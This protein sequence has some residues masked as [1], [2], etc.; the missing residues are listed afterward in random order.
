MSAAAAQGSVTQP[1]FDVL[2]VRL[3]PRRRREALDALREMLAG[4]GAHSLYFV[5]AATANLAAENPAY[6]ETLNRGHLVLN[7]G[8]GVKLAARLQGVVLEDNLVG[9][10]LIAQLLSEPFERPLRVYLLGGRPGVAERAAAHV[11]GLF[12]GVEVAAFADGYCSASEEA[13]VVERIGRLRPDLLLVAMGN[14]LQEQFID[15]HLARLGCRVAAGVGGLF[16]H[17]AG[18]LRRAP[19]WMRRLGL[20]WCQLL[21]QQPHKWRRYLP[22]NL[23]FLWRVWRPQLA[24]GARRAAV[25]ALSFAIALA[26]AEGVV[27]LIRPQILE[28]YPDGLYVPSASRQYKLRPHFRGVFRYPEF[29]TEVRISGQGLREDREYSPAHPGARR[30]LAL[31][32][33]FTMGYSVAADESWVR[34]L[35]RL[36]NAGQRARRYQVINAGVPGYS[37]WQEL[38][39]LEEEGPAFAPDLV[40]LG[41][42]LGNDITDNAAPRLPVALRDGRLISTSFERG[43]LPFPLRLALA[44]HSHLYHLYHLA[45]GDWRLSEDERIAPYAAYNER[46]EAGWS[47]TAEL[48]GRLTQLCN[49]RG[50]RLIVVLMPE[51][52][53][54]EAEAGERLAAELARAGSPFDARLP[55]RRMKE[56]CA[57]AGVEVI[58]L[59]EALHGPGLYFPQDGHWTARGN[60]LAA[61]ALAARLRAEAPP[62][63]QRASLRTEPSP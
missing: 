7:D 15:R 49:A 27:R 36:L 41:F 33:S 22:G 51:R 13:V 14:P 35:E 5:S 37:T 62:S 8:M 39:C 63:E 45:R 60:A 55:N 56:L 28:R 18:E 46:A 1:G 42:F 48:V 50:M 47:A 44:R 20:E 34:R 59:L 58:D 52:A 4:D 30:I 16:D 12:A 31:G 25:A 57:A 11:R 19:E 54:V 2:G 29:Q 24:G 6:R 61:R 10:D 21:I 32:D 17:W 38:A 43:L 40:L 53:Q 26:A 9:T 23:Q 3:R